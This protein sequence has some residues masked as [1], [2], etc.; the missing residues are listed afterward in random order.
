M[1][2]AELTGSR[3]KPFPTQRPWSG[4]SNSALKL[5]TSLSR[6]L[7]PL[8]FRSNVPAGAA[9]GAVGCAEDALD[10]GEASGR[11]RCAPR[12]RVLGAWLAAAGRPWKIGATPCV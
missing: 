8:K 11:S 12:C 10:C 7:V 6:L 3:T 1:L 4:G 2:Y 9:V 5:V